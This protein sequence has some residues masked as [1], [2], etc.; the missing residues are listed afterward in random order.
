M[1]FLASQ[2]QNVVPL[3]SAKS[4]VG[5]LVILGV[6]GGPWVL[7][8]GASGTAGGTREVVPAGFWVFV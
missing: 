3:T 7:G 8:C 2:V 4:G 1:Q 6:G 5:S